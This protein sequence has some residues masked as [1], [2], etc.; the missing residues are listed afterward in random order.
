MSEPVGGSGARGFVRGPQSFV[1]GL[2]LI[3][4]ALFAIWAGDD[5]ARGTLGAIGPGLM[6]FW[7]AIGVGL[8][9][10]AL[11]V[12][13][14]LR[15][16]APLQGMPLRGPVVVLLAIV[17]FA[18]TIRPFAFGS[19]TTPGLGLAVA[20]PLAVLV[21]G[22]ASPEARLSELLILGLLLTA[23]CML[24]F[25]DLLNLPI[26]MLPTAL[27]Q[28]LSGTIP[29]RT[30]LRIAAGILALFGLG[31]LLLNRRS[32]KREPIDVAQHSLTT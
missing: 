9:G 24:L 15:A 2:G 18:V 3:A 32:A 27:I 13:G 29:S 1:A 21:A 19:V 14:L 26:P 12:A 4:L 5:L 7:L 31:L 10:A 6:P 8:C 23:G 17:L 25:G 20:G 16:G 11:C 28:A 30:L 22:Y